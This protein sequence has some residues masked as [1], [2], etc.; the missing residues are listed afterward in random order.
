MT[1]LGIERPLCMYCENRIP[2]KTHRMEVLVGETPPE[3]P[4]H[5]KVLRVTR[6]FP[7]NSWDKPGYQRINVWCGTFRF[8]GLFHAGVCAQYYGFMVARRARSGLTAQRLE[9]WAQ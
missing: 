1:D 5:G 9:G 8:D 2:L 7:P 3:H 4:D 6:R